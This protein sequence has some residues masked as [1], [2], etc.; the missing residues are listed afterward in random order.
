MQTVAPKI[1]L[2]RRR[3]DSLT[4]RISKAKVAVRDL[5]FFYGRVQALHNISLDMKAREVTARGIANSS[6]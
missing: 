6:A 2:P 3:D 1:E 5:N 4:T